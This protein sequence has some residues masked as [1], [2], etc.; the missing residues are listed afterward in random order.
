[1]I[2]LE[3]DQEGGEDNKRWGSQKP[4]KEIKRRPSDSDDIGSLR[5]MM[6]PTES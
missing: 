5:D 2:Q 1:M 4:R 6:M 3:D